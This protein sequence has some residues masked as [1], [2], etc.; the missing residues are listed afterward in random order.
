M[1]KRVFYRGSLSNYQTYLMYKRQLMTLAENVFE[2][3]NLPN[4]IDT[5]FLNKTLLKNGSIVFFVDEV[6][7][8]LALPYNSIGN[9]DVYSRPLKIEAYSSNG[10]R[11]I[12]TDPNEFVIMYDNNG[13]YPIYLDVLQYAERIALSTRTI[14][15]NIRTTKDTK[16]LENAT[17]KSKIN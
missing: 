12:L 9:L 4:F 7:G 16:N 1:A 13:K 17:R 5:A 10:Y 15:I 8:L 2:F 3:V 11:K 14:D 6:M